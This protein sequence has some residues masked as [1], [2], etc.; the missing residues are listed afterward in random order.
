MRRRGR[1]SLEHREYHHY[2]I[3]HH[4]QDRGLSMELLIIM[5][6]LAA[7]TKNWRL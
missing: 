3:S 2:T 7:S 1:N 4:L 5:L 6:N